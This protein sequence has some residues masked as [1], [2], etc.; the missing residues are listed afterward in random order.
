LMDF[1]ETS[2]DDT[3]VNSA[4]NHW[5]IFFFAVAMVTAAANQKTI[6]SNLKSIQ[7]IKKSLNGL[8]EHVL[9]NNCAKFGA[10]LMF[11]YWDT[12]VEL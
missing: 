10:I 4:L 9:Y 1:H 12:F 6:G 2:S 7:D 3:S 5:A 8:I 11:H